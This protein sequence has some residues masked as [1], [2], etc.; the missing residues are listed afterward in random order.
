MSIAG[1]FALGGGCHDN[2]KNHRNGGYRRSYKKD[3]DYGYS[4]SR[5]HRSY[6]CYDCDDDDH[7]SLLGIINI[8]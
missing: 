4:R 2:D 8:G 5:Y 7:H 6:K 1:I 3:H